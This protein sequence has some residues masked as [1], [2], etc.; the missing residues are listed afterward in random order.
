MPQGHMKLEH[1]IFKYMLQTF[2]N[3]GN[4]SIL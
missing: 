2:F 3:S 4:I 1:K